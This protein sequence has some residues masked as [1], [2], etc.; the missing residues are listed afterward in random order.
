MLYQ[1]LSKLFGSLDGRGIFV[2]FV[3]SDRSRR[4]KL[5]ISE[6]DDHDGSLEYVK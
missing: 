1:T 6:G 5:S 4:V 2:T 3:K